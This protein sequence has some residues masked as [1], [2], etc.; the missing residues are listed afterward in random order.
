MSLLRE[1][2]ATTHVG[3]EFSTGS[4]PPLLSDQVFVKQLW[5]AINLKRI[6]SLKLNR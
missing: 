4:K 1:K 2:I 5:P 6:L 3:K